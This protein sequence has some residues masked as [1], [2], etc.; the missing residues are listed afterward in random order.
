[1]NVLPF[2]LGDQR[3]SLTIMSW[4][5]MLLA[6]ILLCGCATS[7]P[8]APARAA[9][10][11]YHYLIGPK[12]S[13]RIIVWR[14][15]ELSMPAVPVRPDGKISTPLVEDLVAIGREPSELARDIEKSL[16]KYI[17]S[18]L[19]TVI[20]MQF[21]GPYSEQVRVVGEATEPQALA[22]VQG[23]TLLDVMI[24]VGGVTEFAA[25]N[26]ATILRQSQGN[27]QFSVRVDDLL[28]DGD[29]A[30]NVEMLPGDVL[31]IPQSWF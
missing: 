3:R 5:V 19:V 16:S 8:P 21:T 26:R 6:M 11:K 20:V 24:Q 31:V 10:A 2:R 7:L 22:Y 29:V 27:K 1:M 30:A 4:S 18:P 13:L 28:K 23:M 9:D 14:N 15:P 25:G 17:R 12:D